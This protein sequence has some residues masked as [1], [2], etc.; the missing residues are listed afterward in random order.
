V[1]EAIED[2]LMHDVWI[3]AEQQERVIP[4]DQWL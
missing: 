3:M 4:D 2:I 1:L